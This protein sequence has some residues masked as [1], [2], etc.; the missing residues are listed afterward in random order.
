M[1]A[2]A[3]SGTPHPLLSQQ[4]PRPPRREGKAAGAASAL[5]RGRSGLEVGFGVG[6]E[7]WGELGVRGEAR[8]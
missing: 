3:E 5:R 8:L 7:T 6:V 2:A 1:P 4:T